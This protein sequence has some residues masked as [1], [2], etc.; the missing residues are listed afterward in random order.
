MNCTGN[1][2]CGI[3]LY[4][5]KDPVYLK[6]N[7]SVC[8]KHIDD[9]IY[10]K[11]PHIT[12]PE[13]N[14]VIEIPGNGFVENTKLKDQI[15]KENYLNAKEKRLKSQLE[16]SLEEFN[17]LLEDLNLKLSEFSVTQFDHFLDLR[18]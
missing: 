6:C 11:Q 7:H 16:K 15:N 9:L 14:E 10:M 4:I 2:T 8:K 3:C 13:C 5:Q 12:C 18:R 1:Y 17:V